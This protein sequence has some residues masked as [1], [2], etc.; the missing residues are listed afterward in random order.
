METTVSRH[1]V[2]FSKFIYKI[3]NPCATDSVRNI[4]SNSAKADIIRN[5]FPKNRL[6]F[7]FLV[8]FIFLVYNYSD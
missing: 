5:P 8:Y 6:S 4:G 2:H 7:V 3:L 1:S